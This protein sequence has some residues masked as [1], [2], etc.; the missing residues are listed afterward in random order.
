MANCL[1]LIVYQRVRAGKAL[2]LQSEVTALCSRVLES[3]LEP[4]VP[5]A[6]YSCCLNVG[7][8]DPE[9]FVGHGDSA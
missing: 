2:T 6:F 4:Q 5:L 3:L 1:P 8:V 9:A 7:G